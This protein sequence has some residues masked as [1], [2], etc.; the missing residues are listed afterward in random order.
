MGGR[1]VIL[2]FIGMGAYYDHPIHGVLMKRPAYT[3]SK[4]Q[5]LL[6]DT[7]ILVLQWILVG[8]ACEISV[9]TPN[10]DDE[11]VP[12]LPLTTPRTPT[13]FQATL[14]AAPPLD[15]YIVDLTMAGFLR[16]LGSRG[17]GSSTSTSPP[18]TVSGRRMWNLSLL[19]PD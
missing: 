13:P 7:T 14:K 10:N 1:R 2:D 15:E 3:P 8:I 16:L 5:L 18:P 9:S 19:R 17:S 12:I 6:L 11:E 4:P